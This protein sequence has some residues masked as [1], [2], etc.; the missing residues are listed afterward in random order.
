MKEYFGRENN[1]TK[2]KTAHRTHRIRKEA[3]SKTNSI[4]YCSFKSYAIALSVS[5]VLLFAVSYIAYSAADPA[6]VVDA[7]AY[8][9]LAVSSLVG[10]VISASLCR[11][12]AIAVSASSGGMYVLSLLIMALACDNINSPLLMLLGYGAS[13]ALFIFGAWLFSKATQ[14]KRRRR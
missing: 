12:N 10:G 4:F 5:A 9:C 13:V 3:K 1:M 11:E 2:A 8:I 14:R 6:A 7:S